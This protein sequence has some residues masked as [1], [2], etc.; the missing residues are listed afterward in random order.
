[1]TPTEATILQPSNSE[2]SAFFQL[3]ERIKRWIWQAGWTEL[4]D[5]QERAIPIILEG[6]RD[7]IIAAATASGK[8]EA[9]YFPILSRMLAQKARCS[10]LYISP[11]K[12]LI[13]D[14]WWRL[15]SLCKDLEIPVIPWHGDIAAS[16]KQ[17]FLEESHGCLLITPESL[18]GMLMREGHSLGRLLDGLQY[19]VVDELHAFIDSE[20]GKQL[21]SL[22]HRLEIALDRQIPRIGLSA[23][24]GE[25]RLAA[26]FLRPDAPENVTVI[27]S[28]DGGQELKVIVKGF[29]NTHPQI[30]V[31][32]IEDRES[33]EQQVER[34]DTLSGGVLAI[35]DDL[36]KTLRGCNNLV[37]PNSRN[38]VELYADLLRRSCDRLGVPNEFW[39]H[40]GSLSKEIRQETERA[41]KV[42][43]SPAT[44]IATTTLELGIDIGTVKS[45]VQIGSAPSVASLRQR[46]GRSGRRKGE[47]AIL[48]CY[49]LEEPL[50]N[51]T[52]LSDQLREGLVETV[53]Q[54]R[55]LLSHWFEPPRTQSMHLSTMIQQLLSLIAQ[56]GGLSAVQAWSMLCTSGLFPSLTKAEFAELLRT[57]GNKDLIIQEPTGLLLHGSV[58]ERIVNHYSFL[59]AFT[60]SDEFRI[61]CAGKQIGTLPLDRPLTVGSFLIFAGR[62]WMVTDCTP[63]EKL[64][65]VVPAKGGKLPLFDGMSGKVH[66]RVREEMRLILRETEPPKFLDAAAMALLREARATYLR[67]D[68]D[69]NS[70][71][72]FGNNVSVF[73]WQGDWANDTLV[74][75]LA[76]RGL[77]AINE[78]LSLT[79]FDAAA[80][81]V[82]DAFL[83]IATSPP[84][85]GA[86]LAVDVKN[87]LREKW[88]G[89]LPEDL[90]CK[91]FA[92][93]D[94]AVEEAVAFAK[95]ITP[96]SSVIS[97]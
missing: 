73:T 30:T 65:A 13:N 41:L 34:E 74:L 51:D 43:T 38:K 69:K 9:A 5:A 1:M 57:L 19:V 26:E 80:E 93:T 86:D 72:P 60:S 76:S 37:F 35:G 90:L 97:G 29:I 81:A 92:S 54:V 56:Y 67:L 23:T 4:K 16:L 28:R 15:E 48:R 78:G 33:A 8:T 66:R 63:Q 91:N 95:Q 32:D 45:I 14:Q 88:D 3:D 12:A 42:G 21:Q 62:R 49:C 55:L 59:A 31:E 68:L 44:A 2:S 70:I 36:F 52:P 58:G 40:H 89:F 39:P 77:T 94:I 82:L 25:M 11:L 6:K 87:K 27:E 53:A 61:V 64:V 17:K 71:V 84:V 20:R 18:E 96:S 85:S 83:D 7:V 10:V 47:A 46:L 50:E 24:L 79:V 22:M 75:L